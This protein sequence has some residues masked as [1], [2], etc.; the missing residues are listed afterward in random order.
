M[1]V[2][3]NL[4]NSS[5]LAYIRGCLDMFVSNELYKEGIGFMN[6]VIKIENKQLESS[7]LYM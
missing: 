3:K 7:F 5:L 2:A 6:K 4:A 1:E